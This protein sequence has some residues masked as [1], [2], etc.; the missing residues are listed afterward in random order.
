MNQEN[1]KVGDELTK[2]EAELHRLKTTDVNGNNEQLIRE[3]TTKKYRIVHSMLSEQRAELDAMEK[4]E[5]EEYT[6]DFSRLFDTPV[7]ITRKEWQSI[8]LSRTVTF[9][10][11]EV[12]DST[13]IGVK[14]LGT[15]LEINCVKS[16]L[17]G[18][19]FGQFLQT[20]K[21]ANNSMIPI[22]EIT[23]ATAF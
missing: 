13:V 14:Y 16:L 7:K 17:D 20:V 9:Y 3:L 2:I 22:S 23:E 11:V 4:R 18:I 21:Y 5:I 1:T 12:E 19:K 6:K 8:A 10:D 15:N